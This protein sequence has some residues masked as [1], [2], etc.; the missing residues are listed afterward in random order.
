FSIAEPSAK[1]SSGAPSMA[2]TVIA[3]MNTDISLTDVKNDCLAWRA[4]YAGANANGDDNDILQ[5]E[6][7]GFQVIK[8]TGLVIKQIK[9]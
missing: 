1:H 7:H 3:L 5:I 4:R 2:T 6:A 8:S 9:A